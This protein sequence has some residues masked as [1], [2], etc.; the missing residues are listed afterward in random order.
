MSIRIDAHQ[1]FWVFDKGLH[2][3]IDDSMAAVQKDFLPK[4]LG[5]VLRKNNIDG[6]VLVQ[7]E[8]S[9]E[10]VEWFLKLAEENP[11]IKAV[12]GWTDFTAADIEERLAYY[13]Q[14]PKLRGFRHVVQGEKD[15]EFLYNASFRRGIGLLQQH[16][17]TYDILIYPHQMKMATDFAAA[18]PEQKFVLDHLGKPYIKKG[19]IDEWKKDLNA[20]AALDNVW[21]KVSGL[22]TE[23]DWQQQRRS[24]FKPYI[25]AAIEAFGTDRLM[26]GSDWPVCL[27]A[28]SYE[29]VLGIVEDAF[30]SYSA[31][32]KDKVFGLNAIE[33][34][35][36]NK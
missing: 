21:C 23:A 22:V 29:N 1:H 13:S 14:F 18:F 7:V 11:F 3:W 24:K 6:C 4:D 20:L 27:V 10:E 9:E 31:E 28:S 30:S 19:L 15:P 34:Y 2:P 33:F 36:L 17:F 32:E 8:H 35:Q 16:N 5:P 25:E 26:F 12:V